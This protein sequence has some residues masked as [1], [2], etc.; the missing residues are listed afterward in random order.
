MKA[1]YQHETE[2]GAVQC[3]LCPHA[4]RLREGQAGICG[5]RAVR[6]GV[7]EALGYGYLSAMQVDPME[8]KPLY[9]FYPGTSVFSVGGW[10]CNF[11]CDFCQ[12]WSIS[13][14]CERSGSPLA[15]AEVAQAALRSGAVALAYTYNEPLVG[16]EFAQDCSR[17]ARSLGLLNVLVTNGYAQSP[18]AGDILKTTDALNI[19]IKSMDEDF[20]RRF[21]R[22][23][24]APT[25]AF[26][27]QA[28]RSACHLEITCLLIPGLNDRP[29]NLARLADWVADELGPETP[30]HLSGYRPGYRMRV[31]ATADA[32]LERAAALC[33]T[34][35]SYVYLGNTTAETG[36]DTLCVG[37]GAVLIQRLGYA[38]DI[39][40][41]R[42]G[43]CAACGRAAPIRMRGNGGGTAA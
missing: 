43:A 30:L 13:Q 12:N 3:D 6:D 39:T 9:H 34:R 25:L 4:C 31:A 14:R 41:L 17:A 26:A 11:S 23:R 7:L 21:C 38:V 33:R 37:C 22:G 16:I 5:V 24:L 8:K 29:E 36:R 27:Q 32:D 10:G 20:Y 42:D 28:A 1:R 40:G 2:D 35:L 15:P 19:D 18:A